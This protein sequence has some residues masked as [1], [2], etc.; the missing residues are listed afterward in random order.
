M[1]QQ[2]KNGVANSFEETKNELGISYD[3]SDIQCILLDAIKLADY[4]DL[5]TENL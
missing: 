1:M 5:K 2:K 4:S 3:D